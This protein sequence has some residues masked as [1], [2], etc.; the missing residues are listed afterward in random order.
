[1]ETKFDN[2]TYKEIIKE[3]GREEGIIF[4]RQ[5]NAANLVDILPDDVI[6]DRIGLPVR[7]VEKIREEKEN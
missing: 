7:E 3:E 5:E 6:A 1:M 4:N 2:N